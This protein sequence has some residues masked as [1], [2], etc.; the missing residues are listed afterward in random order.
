MNQML[1]NHLKITVI[2]LLCLLACKSSKP[3]ASTQE[4][5]TSIAFG[6]CNRQDKPQPMWEYIV[7]NKPDLWIWL[8]DNIYG[9]SDTMQVL[10]RK[11][12]LQQNNPEYRKLTA[13]VPIIGIW[14][15][16]DY[17]R[18]DAGKEYAH[19]KES[20]QLMLDFLGEPAIS[21]R[22][23]QEGAYTSYTYGPVGKQVKVI[24]LD[25]R[26]FRDALQKQDKAYVINEKGD[27][28]GET[29]WKWLENELKN[30]KADIHLIGS[31]IQIIP[32]EHMYEKWANFPQARKRLLDL[33]AS[34]RTQ[35]VIL[36]SGDRHIAEISKYTL[37]GLTAPIYEV[38]AS[39]LTH[40]STNN[41]GEPNQYR[42][43]NLVNVLNFGL[44]Q[45]DW[46]QKPIQVDLI[47]KGLNNEVL[48]KETIKY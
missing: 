43:G 33:L 3:T 45:I 2:C 29:Q 19:K 47:I 31:G 16:H 20:Q 30:S 26:Y 15:D 46:N 25:A 27:I 24:L 23:K 1:T 10:K 11:Y 48:L 35:H 44:L 21:P 7:Q 12:E 6:S 37:P 4:A 41:T 22:R 9:D 17:G 28:L 42:V 40:S 8:G 34:T 14:D 18:N 13:A 39:G 38:T 5:L 32:D 36:L